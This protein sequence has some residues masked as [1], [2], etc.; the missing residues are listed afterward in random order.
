MTFEDLA[1]QTIEVTVTKATQTAWSNY[2][3]TCVALKISPLPMT[4]E[5]AKVYL[6]FLFVC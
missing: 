4:L 1:S 5:K 2:E 3:K 6:K